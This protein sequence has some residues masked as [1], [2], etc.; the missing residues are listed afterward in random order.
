[1]NNPTCL[2]VL[3]DLNLPV[4]DGMECAA[5][6][7]KENR[8]ANVAIIAFSSSSE[9]MSREQVPAVCSCHALARLCASLC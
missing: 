5:E 1:M 7:R 4:M 6:I 3:M 9:L 2:T 8:L